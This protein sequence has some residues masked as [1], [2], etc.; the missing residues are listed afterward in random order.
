MSL[1]EAA[2]AG[3][4]LNGQ[5]EEEEDLEKKIENDEYI[6][7]MRAKDEYHD[8]HRRGWGNRMNRS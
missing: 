7:R 4:S 2:I 3:M 6:E 1:Q 8:E 5:D